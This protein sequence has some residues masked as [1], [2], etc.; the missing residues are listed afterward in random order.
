MV[1]AKSVSTGPAGEGRHYVK[2]FPLT[3]DADKDR[4]MEEFRAAMEAVCMLPGSIEKYTDLDPRIDS[5][6]WSRK[7][8]GKH[9][10]LIH[11]ARAK[12]REEIRRRVGIFKNE[13]DQT[14]DT[15]AVTR[16]LADAS[17]HG[18]TH[19]GEYFWIKLI[20]E[21]GLK[22]ASIVAIDQE[23]INRPKMGGL[24]KLPVEMHE[25][26]VYY[27]QTLAAFT[28]TAVELLNQRIQE[29]GGIKNLTQQDTLDTLA[30]AD[31]VV[32]TRWQQ[33]LLELGQ[34]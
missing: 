22:D 13:N 23:Y 32:K 10:E 15:E 19:G 3:G 7:R 31:N 34:K 11:Y 4:F 29:I 17:T 21:G 33:R 1:P 28:R 27:R 6:I 8:N 12:T 18:T 16:I 24:K 9:K 26:Y 5:G 14:P 20:D 25:D 30:I 2:P